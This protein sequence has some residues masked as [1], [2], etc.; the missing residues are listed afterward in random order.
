MARTIDR[1]APKAKSRTPRSPK[2]GELR[3]LFLEELKDLY[4]AEQQLTK[5][6][7]KMAAAAT[8]GDLRSAFQQH[9]KETQGHVDRLDRIV[10]SLGSSPQGKKCKGMEG[11]VQEGAEL[12]GEDMDDNVKDAGLIGAA[13][14]VEHYEMA[15]Y[16]T[17]RA[18]AEQLAETEAARLLQQTLDEEERADMKLTEIAERVNM[19]ASDAS[20][21]EQHDGDEKIASRVR[22]SARNRKGQGR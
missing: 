4:N 16:G 9:L 21:R 2:V 11:L 20:S 19:Q 1:L 5:A 13:Q 22:D 8:S 3:D 15:G 17:A 6:L 18:F 14:R 7:P 12:I 10:R